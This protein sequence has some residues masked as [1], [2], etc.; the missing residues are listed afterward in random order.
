[1]IAVLGLHFPHP[2]FLPIRSRFEIMNRLIVLCA[3]PASPWKHRD[4]AAKLS[5]AKLD[6]SR[7]IVKL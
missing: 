1:L 6:R 4:E 5:V 2:F 7:R 3:A